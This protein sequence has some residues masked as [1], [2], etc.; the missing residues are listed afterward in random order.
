MLVTH[1]I[2]LHFYKEVTETRTLMYWSLPSLYCMES[3]EE[4]DIALSDNKLPSQHKQ[5]YI[6]FILLLQEQTN[7]YHLFPLHINFCTSLIVNTTIAKQFNILFWFLDNLFNIFF[8]PLN[9]IIHIFSLA[10][11][12]FLKLLLQTKY[13][14]TTTNKG[15]PGSVHWKKF[16]V[17]IRITMA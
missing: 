3:L 11:W 7:P 8:S 15:L 16:P 5:I 14:V 4:K 2:T 12:Q 10:F 13:L 6:P 17:Q 1:G 9:Y